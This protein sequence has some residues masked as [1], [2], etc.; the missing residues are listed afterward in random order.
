M[1]IILLEKIR[2][3][4]DLGD[5][6]AVKPGFGRN[7][8]IPRGKAVRATPENKAQFEARRAELERQQQDAL[9]RAWARGEQVAGATV[10]IVRKAGDEGKLFGSV[11]TSD[12]AEALVAA[13]FEIAKS[14]IQ[15]PNGPLKEIGDHELQVS[16][17][18]EVSVTII[19][20]V[21]GES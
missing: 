7:F 8:L 1:Q 12:I 14:E 16:L 10:Q 9:K 13:G 4:G 2:N 19:V 18:S 6:V 21:V 11:G 15:L 17:H 5:E 20:S 3:L